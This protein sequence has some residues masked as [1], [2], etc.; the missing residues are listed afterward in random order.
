MKDRGLSEQELLIE[1]ETLKAENRELKKKRE[2]FEDAMINSFELF[3]L[4]TLNEKV[5]FK[6]VSPS[7][8]NILS[9]KP[10]ELIG[11]SYIDLIHPADQKNFTELLQYF[12]EINKENSNASD[13]SSPQKEIDLRLKIKNGD[14][15]FLQSKFSLHNKCLL[16]VSRDVTVLRRTENELKR[17]EHFFSESGK[18]AKV[19]AWELLF[20]DMEFIITENLKAI[21]EVP[22]NDK[23]FLEDI[24][25]L[26]H[27]DD[28]MLAQN[29]WQQALMGKSFDFQYRIQTLSGKTKWLHNKGVSEYENGKIIKIKGVLQDVTESKLAENEILKI[30]KELNVYKE[31]LEKQV[32]E[33]TQK[34]TL[35]SKAVESSLACIIITDKEGIIEYVNESFAKTTGYEVKEV[36]G[37]KLSFLKSGVHPQEFYYQLWNTINQG[38]TWKGD[39]CNKKKNGELFWE[40]AI[41]SPVKNAADEITQFIAIKEEITQKRKDKEEL[42][43]ANMLSST[44]LKLSN[45]GYWY[46][47]FGAE[48]LKLFA[49]AKTLVMYGMDSSYEGTGIDVNVW[50][51]G[52]AAIDA[53]T[54][55]QE[56]KAL[57]YAIEHRE[58]NYERIYPFKRIN[59][60]KLVWFK[61][62]GEKWYDKTGKLLRMYGFSQD[63]TEQVSKE[64]EL[65]ESRENLQSLFDNMTSGLTV[66]ELIR[67]GQGKAIDF[68]INSCNN[69]YKKIHTNFSD[70]DLGKLFSEL[71]DISEI[72]L[73]IFD[74][75]VKTRVPYEAEVYSASIEKFLSL[76]V[77][78][79]NK[80]RFF[81]LFEDITE[82]KQQESE[83]IESREQ[84]EILFENMVTG[85][86]ENEVI[87]D[88]EGKP[89]DIKI[90]RFNSA[91]KQM[92]PTLTEDVKGKLLK[93]TSMQSLL[94]INMVAEVAKGGVP[95]KLQF[96]NNNHHYN[97][98]I[99]SP[100]LNHYAVLVEDITQRVKQEEILQASELR[101][102]NLFENAP[103][104]YHSLDNNGKYIDVN[105][106]YLNL[107]GYSREELIGRSFGDLW[108]QPTNETFDSC[109]NSLMDTGYVSTEL[110][111]RKKDGSELIVMLDGRVQND[112]EGN[113]IRIHCILVDIHERKEQETKIKQKEQNFRNLFEQNMN[114]IFILNENGSLILDCNK[115]GVSL[116]HAE[117]KNQLIDRSFMLFFP[118]MQS[119]G[120]KTN[121][122]ITD[123]IEEARKKGH[124]EKHYQL[125]AN[126]DSLFECNVNLALTTYNEQTCVLCMIDDITERKALEEKLRENEL[127][128]QFSIEGSNIGIWD[129]DFESGN[130]HLS[131]Q[132]CNILGYEEGEVPS[133]WLKDLRIIH[134]EDQD[135]V[136]NGMQYHIKNKTDLYQNEHRVVCKDGSYKW[137]LDRGKVVKWS[138]DGQPSRVVGTYTDISDVKRMQEELAEAKNAA[139]SIIDN[140]PNPVVVVDLH[141]SELLRFNPAA[142]E[143]MNLSGE[144]DN[145]LF[146]AED[147]S[148]I[149]S[150]EDQEML[151]TKLMEQG[152]VINAELQLYDQVSNEKRESL[153]SLQPIRYESR[154]CAVAAMLDITELKQFQNEL[155]QQTEMRQILIDISS[156][157]INIDISKL[158][159]AI[160]NALDRIGTFIDSSR[161]TVYEY[162]KD[163]TYCSI[164][165][166]WCNEGVPQIKGPVQDFPVLQIMPEWLEKQ[167]RNEINYYPD[168][169]KIKNEQ[170]RSHL[171]NAGFKGILSIPMIS[172]NR[173]IGF[174]SFDALNKTRNYS[175]QEIE[176]LQLFCQIL[177]NINNRK[178]YENQIL[179]EKERAQTANK[180][181]SSFLANMSHE[182]RTPMNAIIG[183]SEILAK[184]VEDSTLE[185]YVNSIHSSSKTLLKLINDILDLSKIEAGKFQLNYEAVKLANLFIDIE[186]LFQ[187]KAKEKGLNLNVSISENIPQGLML[188]ELRL[189]QV[190]INVVS[191]ALKF[192]HKGFVK[193][194][195]DAK[196]IT[197]KN[198]TLVITIEDTGVG[199]AKDKLDIIFEDF[200]QQDESISRHYGGT[201]LGLGISKRIIHLFNGDL[202][203]ESEA[204]KGSKFII[205]IPDV[206][207][208]EEL[209]TAEDE[210]IV[211]GDIK[212]ERAKILIVD[213]V[214]SNRDLLASHL[215]LLGF[216]VY[217]A[218]NG[219]SGFAQAVELNPALI[220]M[221]IRMPGED[222]NEVTERLK[223]NAETSHIPIVACTASVLES[224][225]KIVLSDDFNATL[226]KPILTEELI[227][228]LVQYFKYEDVDD[229]V[230]L[231]G[232]AVLTSESVDY[233]KKQLDDVWKQ[234]KLRKTVKGQKII[235]D[236]IIKAGNEIN[237]HNLELLGIEFKAAISSFNLKKVHE[238]LNKLE[239]ILG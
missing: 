202:K 204:G 197:S 189:N 193:L 126:N 178:E 139:D 200:K 175:V 173:L 32:E 34:L 223:A 87:F 59:D 122:K 229:E 205:E 44:A 63:I 203:V 160:N 92:V 73:N 114:A 16:I 57:T 88:D 210:K 55:E 111:L 82:R 118:E 105:N 28:M 228:I 221:D 78:P 155:K 217:E 96:E 186:M 238:I 19:G 227:N 191:N 180:A 130:V 199:I 213:D 190:L 153:I 142:K 35:F 62:V 102:R 18:I 106:W 184:K 39:I 25:K 11:K 133:D 77:F 181:K 194:N 236:I 60:G 162:N 15:V 138:A 100:K 234:A 156:N 14:Y 65:I 127:R 20:P 8:V 218:E 72:D 196:R 93:D 41:I 150:A 209:I 83:I 30:N 152:A 233:L 226:T 214:K 215:Q 27:P 64:K 136:L 33:R 46:A 121:I 239:S 237:S 2:L 129:W 75:V 66:S 21:I 185:N 222:G 169:R 76:R 7:C 70:N 230:H 182:I 12:S 154:D 187:H 188:D 201:G 69:A 22:A 145:K 108:V 231:E 120:E 116:F 148:M 50:L 113:A 58:A 74:Q 183:F 38:F 110:V 143:L 61:V 211:N 144:I 37:Q 103:V 208:T 235:A 95:K 206:E 10:N 67:D 112:E 137:V 97:L 192:T 71:H 29:T 125:K 26:M 146:S 132:L 179:I 161:I 195:A 159:E 141:T 224:P 5:E 128:W 42:E 43:K 1:I 135:I 109:V 89:I 99:F 107:L 212:F 84:F 85:F 134:P 174:V 53:K 225:E 13:I 157:Y 49:A 56:H 81:S 86:A 104:A 232:S 147:S 171:V 6:Y 68:R 90:L 45:T 54:A 163:I 158:G 101:F 119:D 198:L 17:K 164:R 172:G 117:A 168:V 91:L 149:I 94:D 124:C 51:N 36:I 48:P 165:Y 140:N 98:N 31:D 3:T 115:K 219:A 207:I 131:K 52:I 151:M 220:F 167:K 4:L 47:D 170:L 9:Y 177:I 79:D 24:F 23:L 176:L 80:G 123:H 166:Q 216:D 40:S